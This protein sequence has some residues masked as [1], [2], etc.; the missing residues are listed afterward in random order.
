M[1]VLKANDFAAHRQLLDLYPVL[2]DG[3]ILSKSDPSRDMKQAIHT[4]RGF[5]QVDLS[6]QGHQVRAYVHILVALMYLPIPAGKFAYLVKHKN[7][8]QSNNH[9]DN[10]EWWMRDKQTNAC[11]NCGAPITV[12]ATSELQHP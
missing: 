12:L 11:P 1:R 9:M 8:D 5:V 7:G 10:L 3:R 2:P 6:T 4:S